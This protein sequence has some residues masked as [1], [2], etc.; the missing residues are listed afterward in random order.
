MAHASF[1][2]IPLN[3]LK[4]AGV[5]DCRWRQLTHGPRIAYQNCEGFAFGGMMRRICVS[6]IAEI[7][8]KCV[9]MSAASAIYSL[10]A[11]GGRGRDG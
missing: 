6:K 4:I 5:V 10:Q 1:D 2:A 3:T 7:C 9:D 11:E 8:R